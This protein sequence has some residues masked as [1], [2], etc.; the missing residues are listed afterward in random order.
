VTGRFFHPFAAKALRESGLGY[1]PGDPTL[2]PRSQVAVHEAFS[3]RSI[4][5]HHGSGF[6]FW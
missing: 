2:V 3:G 5:K 1:W 6:I 4:E